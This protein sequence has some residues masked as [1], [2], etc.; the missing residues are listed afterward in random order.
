M[1]LLHAILTL[2]GFAGTGTNKKR[3]MASGIR[4]RL[5]RIVSAYTYGS[6]SLPFSDA[7]DGRQSVRASACHVA[8]LLQSAARWAFHH[9][10]C[11]PYQRLDSRET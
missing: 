10:I 7:R 4:S 3:I 6:N 11:T 8:G 1:L 9:D 2:E 5:Q